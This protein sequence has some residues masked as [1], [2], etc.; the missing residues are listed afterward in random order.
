M[1]NLGLRHEFHSHTILSD[2]A[3]LPVAL[4]RE[5]VIKNHAVLAI[6]D[7][8][9]SSNLETV[10]TSLIKVE[11]ET[12]GFIPIKFIPGVEV[13]YMPPPLIEKLS[14]RA[15]KYGAKII[16][17]HGQSPSEPVEEGTNACAVRL[18][19][20]VNI[21]A[22]PGFIS[23]EDVL[24]AAKNNVFLE[25]SAKESHNSANKHIATLAKK[26]KALLLVNTDAHNEKNL[27]TQEQ[28]FNVAKDAGLTD[29][30]AMQ[31]IKMNP[32]ELLAMISQ[33]NR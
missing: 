6:T 26:H 20:L 10:L 5:A 1:E 12:K 28:A 7:H 13:S 4:M 32:Q 21:L 25:L 24:L 9:D 8:V 14:K 3:L 2:G 30:E 19:G 22:H 16:I 18:K 11:K 23:E 15:K 33:R 29:E 17:V 27:I 31:T